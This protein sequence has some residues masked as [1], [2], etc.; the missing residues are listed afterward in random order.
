MS[1]LKEIYGD[2]KR[3]ISKEDLPKMVYLERVIKE[4]LRL[5]PI[6]P[7]IGRVVT[8]E[9]KLGRYVLPVGAICGLGIYALH[10]DKAIWGEDVEEFDPDRFLPENET[11]RD[12]KCYIPFSV[13]PRNCIGKQYAMMSMKSLVSTVLRKYKLKSNLDYRTIQVKDELVLKPVNGHLISIEH[14]TDFI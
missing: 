6:G 8:K 4:T 11:K 12:P 1:R 5:F 7:I 13:G 14:R 9:I 2:S 3:C 10:H